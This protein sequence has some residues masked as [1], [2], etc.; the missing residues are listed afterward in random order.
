MSTDTAIAPID[1]SRAIGILNAA[2]Q[3]DPPMIP[4]G[5]MPDTDADKIIAAEQILQ[6]ALQADQVAQQIGT[7]NVPN[8][9]VVKEVLAEAYVTV[10]VGS[11]PG[12]AT[13]T[14]LA[15]PPDIQKMADETGMAI[16]GSSFT[17]PPGTNF[18]AEPGG[19]APALTTP[20]VTDPGEIRQGENW[21]DDDGGEWYVGA[22]QTYAQD[23]RAAADALNE[24][25]GCAKGRDRR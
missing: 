7:E 23:C 20:A 10:G 2:S 16:E 11:P 22:A 21:F 8:Y 4:A 1:I 17:D 14:A 13:S 12:P 3:A 15:P 18:R 6:L 5:G 19:E 25:A 9:N 24:A